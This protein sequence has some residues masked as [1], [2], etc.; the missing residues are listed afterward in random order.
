MIQVLATDPPSTI[1]A[2][3]QL[4]HANTCRSTRMNY[5]K[6]TTMKPDTPRATFQTPKMKARTRHRDRTRVSPE[7]RS[8]PPSLSI[9]NADHTL[10]HKFG[11]GWPKTFSAA[12][13]CEDAASFSAERTT[14]LRLEISTEQSHPVQDD[15][16]NKVN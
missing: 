15:P 16:V 8:L 2:P 14:T 10:Q 13:H 11:K 7:R 6:P 3:Q 1:T 12:P 5:C 4:Q 9:C